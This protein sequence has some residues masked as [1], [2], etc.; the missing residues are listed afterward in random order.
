MRVGN[1]LEDCLVSTPQPDNSRDLNGPA[2]SSSGL[3]AG[4]GGGTSANQQTKTTMRLTAV[5]S[6]LTGVIRHDQESW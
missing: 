2:N 1:P 6:V 3:G 4:L 5:R